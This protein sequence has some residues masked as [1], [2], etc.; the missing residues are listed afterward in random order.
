M[1]RAVVA[2][3]DLAPPPGSVTVPAGAIQ[4]V[5]VPPP[6]AP[7]APADPNK[8]FTP[9]PDWTPQAAPAPVADPTKAELAPSGG[10]QVKKLVL[11]RPHGV[12]AS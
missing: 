5:S 7:A 12:I 4:P 1:P 3:I 8:A 6:A 9:P 11:R 2:S 10:S